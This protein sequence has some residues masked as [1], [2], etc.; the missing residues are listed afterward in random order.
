M[1]KQKKNRSYGGDFK[2]KIEEENVVAEE[3]IEN[4]ETENI[5]KDLDYEK[6]NAE[7]ISDQEQDDKLENEKENEE[8]NNEIFKNDSDDEISEDFNFETAT[9][10]KKGHWI[11]DSSISYQIYKFFHI[12]NGKHGTCKCHFFG[13]DSNG[14]KKEFIF[15]GHTKVKIPKFKRAK[16]FITNIDEIEKTIEILNESKGKTESIDLPDDDLGQ[17]IVEKFKE[18]QNVEI[19]I[20]EFSN[21][22]VIEAVSSKK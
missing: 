22:K 5:E 18:T 8:E 15:P 16:F 2:D 7:I 13:K 19:L 14:K 6:E 20:R 4:E 3:K 1:T 17:E 9:N 21:Q 11:V 12:K 10:I